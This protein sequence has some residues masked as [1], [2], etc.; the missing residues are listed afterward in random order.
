MELYLGSVIEP[1]RKSIRNTLYFNN[2]HA[3]KTLGVAMLKAQDLHIKHLYSIGE[4]QQDLAVTT[5]DGLP[6]ITVSEMNTHENR[7][8]YRNRRESSE[9][10]QNSHETPRAMTSY[11]KKVTFDRGFST[12]TV[13]DSEISN[14]R[15]T[16]NL[17]MKFLQSR[18]KT[19]HHSL[20]Y[21]VAHSR[22]SW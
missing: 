19:S 4:E 16:R 11:N 13:S 15:K 6:E 21:Y 14:P 2:K 20:R 10:L 9:H 7:G 17:Q 3:P 18:I 8:W 22:K 1:I 5:S 12:K